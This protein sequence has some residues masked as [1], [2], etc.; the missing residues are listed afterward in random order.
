MACKNP[1]ELVSLLQEE[2]VELTDEQLE[3]VVGGV[4]TEWSIEGIFEWLAGIFA[5]LFPRGFDAKSVW[6]NL[7]IGETH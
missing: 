1:Q 5:G 6:G 4:G 3:A 7:P 2:D